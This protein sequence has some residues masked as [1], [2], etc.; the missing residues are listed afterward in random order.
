MNL[1]GALSELS[2]ALALLVLDVLLGSRSQQRSPDLHM[3]IEGGQVQR[4]LA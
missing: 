3:S 1:P 2:Q 4:H